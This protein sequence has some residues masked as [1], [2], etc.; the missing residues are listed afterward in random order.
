MTRLPLV[1]V[2]LLATLALIGCGTVEVGDLHPPAE[3]DPVWVDDDDVAWSDGQEEDQGD[4]WEDDWEDDY[5]DWGDDCGYTCDWSDWRDTLV[6]DTATFSLI[7]VDPINASPGEVV[8]IYVASDDGAATDLFSAGDFLVCTFDGCLPWLEVT[9][10]DFDPEIDPEVIV[11][12]SAFDVEAWELEGV[13]VSSMEFAVP[14]GSV[15]GDGMYF[16][17]WPVYPYPCFQLGIW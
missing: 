13:T 2:A 12:N 1:P 17:P 11:L 9:P 4:E 5:D 6:E 14:G 15:S 16:P 8:T 10:F 3:H 7:G